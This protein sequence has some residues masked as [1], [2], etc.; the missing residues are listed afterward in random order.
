[1]NNRPSFIGPRHI[2]RLRQ[3]IFLTESDGRNVP[4]LAP[5]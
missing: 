2:S 3:G 1:M 5:W 4:E